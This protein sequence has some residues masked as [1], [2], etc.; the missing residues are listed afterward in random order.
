LAGDAAEDVICPAGKLLIAEQLPDWDPQKALL[1][2]YKQD[3]ESKYGAGSATTFGGHA[4]DALMM[5]VE[6]LKN[7]PFSS[8]S[9]S[10]TH[11]TTRPNLS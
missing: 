3:F 6:A 10:H 2:E 9:P 8:L 4:Y 5:A 7:S 1:L 11:S